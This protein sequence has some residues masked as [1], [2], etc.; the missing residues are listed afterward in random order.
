MRKLI[1]ASALVACA[2]SNAAFA[3]DGGHGTPVSNEELSRYFAIQ[4]DG[5]GLPLGSGTAKVGAGLFAQ[6]CAMCHGDK[7]QGV[8]A[9]GG[10]ALIGGRGSLSSEKPLKTVESYWPY[11]S[12]LFDYVWRAMPFTEPGSLTPDEVYAISAYILEQGK[13][14]DDKIV[15]DAKSLPK[16]VMPNANGFYDGRGS[17]LSAY[18]G[19]GTN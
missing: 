19:Q 17:D 6:K 12:T 7:L 10:P 11:T 1:A 14:I 16:V 5:E 15:L 2:L 18:S 8:P 9:T 4:P 3:A 13:I